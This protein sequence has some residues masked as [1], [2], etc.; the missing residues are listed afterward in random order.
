[1]PI[2]NHL[3]PN[4][5][6]SVL[7]DALAQK[8]GPDKAHDYW[9]AIRTEQFLSKPENDW[10]DNITD[11]LLQ[12]VDDNYE[13]SVAWVEEKLLGKVSYINHSGGAN[14]SD[15][16]WDTIGHEFGVTDHRHYWHGKQTPTGNVEITNEQ[17]EEGW[18][19]VKEANK[20]LHR[21]PDAYKSLL[22]RNWFQVKNAEAIF[23]IGKLAGPK[24]V[25]GGTGWAVQMAI[26]AR[27][28]V[29]MYDQE[30]AQWYKYDYSQNLF[31]P[32]STPVLTKN[33]A[34]IGTRE[35]NSLGREAIKDVYKKT[36]A[37]QKEVPEIKPIAQPTPTEIVKTNLEPNDNKIRGLNTRDSEEVM[38]D[39]VKFLYNEA[40]ANP[41][42]LYHIDYEYKGDKFRFPSGYTARELANIFDGSGTSTPSNVRFTEG[43][44]RL[45][46]NSSKRILESLPRLPSDII[47]RDEV[48]ITYLADRILLPKYDD[49]GKLQGYFKASEQQDIIDSALYLAHSF[50]LRDPNFGANAIVKTFKGFQ[51]YAA[52]D[53]KSDWA[54]VHDQ[55][56]R[57]AEEMLDQM[58]QLGYSVSPK[59]RFKILQAVERLEDLKGLDSKVFDET[60][61][62]YDEDL[63][64][65]DEENKQFIE[66]VGHGLKDWGEVS[67]EHDPKDTASARMKMFIATLPD[68]DR[69]KF[70]PDEKGLIMSRPASNLEKWADE[71]PREL[72]ALADQVNRKGFWMEDRTTTERMASILEQAHPILPRKTFLNTPKLID[73][74]S[75][76]QDILETLADSPVHDYNTYKGVLQATG[77]PNLIN[78]VSALDKAD[79]QVRN[80]FARLVSMQ[81]T[82]FSM[83]LFNKSEDA[84]GTHYTLRNIVSNRY[85]Q[86]NTIVKN[87]RENQKLSDIMKINEL[88]QR[89]IDV[90]R[91]RNKW[92]NAL[93]TLQKLDWKNSKD[94]TRGKKFIQDVLNIS[95]VHLTDDMMDYLFGQTK[96]K[97][98][99]QLDEN[100]WLLTKGTSLA[101]GIKK[102]FAVSEDGQPLG[103]FSAFIMKMAGIS[104]ANDISTTE[105][106][107]DIESRAEMNNPLYTENTTMQILSKVAAMFTPVL[108]SGTSKSSEGKTIWDYTMHTKLSHQ[109][110]DL[111]QNTEEFLQRYEGVDIAK[112]NFLLKTLKDVPYYKDR[113]RLMYMD[114]MK[115]QWGKRGTTRANMSDREQMLMSLSLFQNQGN[116]F[117]KVPS[118]HYMS[119]THSDKTTTPLLMNMPKID[120]GSHDKTPAWVV[121]KIDSAFY[122]IFKAE[123][124][125][126][127]NQSKIDFNDSRYD[128]GKSLFYF[129]P[130]FNK[131]AMSKMVETGFLSDREFKTIWSNGDALTK[132]I[133]EPELGVINKILNK[134]VEDRVNT[135]LEAW[136]KNGIVTEDSHLFDKKYTDKLLAKVGIKAERPETSDV[137]DVK[138][139]Y[140]KGGQHLEDAEIH[141]ITVRYAAKDYA[142]NHFIHNVGMS[143]LF[144]GD[145]A[146]TFKKG[147]SDMESVDLTLKEYGKRL[148]KDIAPGLDPYFRP[149]DKEFN[150]I[151]LADVNQKEAY[152]FNLDKIFPDYSKVNGTDAQEFTTVAEHLKVAYANGM[153]TTKTFDEMMQIVNNSNG[154]YYEFTNPEHLSV[155][156]QPVKPV[157]AGK[158]SAQD[159]AILE[160]YIKTSSIPLYPPATS[161]LELDGLRTYMEK[162]NLD[163][164]PFESGKKIGSP[165]NPVSF[166]SSDGKFKEPDITTVQRGTVRL[167]RSGFR[168]QQEVPYDETKEAIKTVSQMNKLI[169]EGID[170]ISNFKI[171]GKT[172]SGSELRQMKEDIRK[173]MIGK[174]Y[175]DFLQSW[176]IDKN[177]IQD[178]SIIYDKLLNG[179]GKDRLS[180]NERISLSARDADGNLFIPLQFNT[181]ADNLESLLMSMVKDIAQVKMPGKSFVQASSVGWKFKEGGV[182]N[183]KIVWAEDHHGGSLRTL[184]KDEITGEMKPAEVLIPFNFTDH[185]G[186]PMNV[187]DFMIEK[188]GK[189]ILD[190]SKVPK[191][192]T[193]LIGARI[194]NQGH[195]SMAAI[196]VVG[197]LPKNMG[198]TVVVPAGFT[199]QMGAD[200]DVDKLYTYRR[201]YKYDPETRTFSQDQEEMAGHQTDYFNVHWSVLTH[202]EMAERILKP[203]DK[204]DL[205]EENE[206]L[207]PVKQEGYNYF[208]H[209]SQLQDFQNGKDAK[210]L[211]GLTSLAVTFNAV[212]Q[213]K[214]LHFAQDVVHVSPEGK[215]YTTLERSHILIKDEH[216]GELRKLT[217]L[218]GNGKSHYTR[219]DG[220]AIPK[221]GSSI[222]TKS[223][224]HS[225]VQSAAVDN[226]KDRAL[227]NLNVTPDTYPAL[228]A[229]LQLETE[230]GWAA[231]LKYGT[232]LLTQPIIKEFATEMKKGNDSLSTAYDANLK[233]SVIN[234]LL[235]KYEGEHEITQEEL[236]AVQFDPQLLKK[237]QEMDPTSK[238]YAIHQVAALQLFEKLHDLGERKSQI[239][240]YFNQDTQGA[241]PN[242][243]TALDKSDKLTKLEQAPIAGAN[244]IFWN[245]K[246]GTTEQGYTASATTGVAANILTQLLPYDKYYPLFNRLTAISGRQSMSIDDQRSVLRATRS[247]LYNSGQHWW[248]DAHAER[249]RLF[250][251]QGESLSLARRLEQVKR[252]WGKDNYF[253]QRLDPVIG[254]TTSTPDFLEY[255][256]A[257]VGRIDEENNNRA[258]TELLMSPE[259]EKRKLGEDLLRYAFL[260]GGVQDQNSFVKFAPAAYIS[261]T[262]FGNMLKDKGERLLEPDMNAMQLMPGFEHQY[263]QHNPEKAFQITREVFGNIPAEL[264]YPETFFVP[265]EHR[266]KLL[267]DP[268]NY[269]YRD[270]VSYRSPSENKWVLY[271]NNPGDISGAYTRVDILGNTYTDEY[272]G[273]RSGIIR[274]IFTENRAMA[275][276]LPAMSM[277]GMAQQDINEDK[278]FHGTSHY[279]RLGIREGKGLDHMEK[280]L[281]NIRD[282]EEVPQ[283]LRAVADLFSKSGISKYETDAR[284]LMK[285]GF[286]P[287]IEFQSKAGVDGQATYD[288][289]IMLNPKTQSIERAA[290]TYLHEYT[291]QRLMHIIT[292]AGFDVSNRK[293]IESDSRLAKKYK[294]IQE[295]FEKH[296]PEAVEHL[297]QLDIMRYTVNQELRRRVGEQA[298]REME[299]KLADGKPLN[300]DEVLL[301]H[302]NNLQEFVTGIM[303]DRDTQELLNSFKSDN[304][305][306]SFLQKVWR[307]LTDLITSIFKGFKVDKESKL[308]EAMY[309]TI[310]LLQ[311]NSEYVG[312]ITDSLLSGK[313]IRVPTEKMSRGLRGA[314]EAYERDPDITKDDMGLTIHAKVQKVDI[315][316]PIGKITDRLKD[317]L[318]KAYRDISKGTKQERVAAR[319]RYNELRQDYNDLVRERNQAAIQKIAKKQLEWID[320]VLVSRTKNA[321]ITQAAIDAANIWGNMT[322]IMYGD[323]TGFATPDPTLASLEQEAQLNRI[324]LVNRNAAEVV[325]NSLQ[326]RVTIMPTDLKDNLKDVDTA[327]SLFLTLSRVK[328]KLISGIG[329]MTR[330]AANN[331]DE[332]L[333]RVHERLMGLEKQMKKLNIRS[334]D[335]LQEKSWGLLDRISNGW[336]EHMSKLNQ[337]R[338]QTLDGIAKTEGLTEQVKRERVNKTWEK[339]WQDVKKTNTFVDIRQLFNT[340]DGS[341]LDPAKIQEATD[342]LAQEV[343]SHEYAKEL[344]EK[345]RGKFKDY[346]EERNIQKEW[347]DSQIHLSDEEKKGKTPQEQEAIR[348]KRMEDEL[349]KWLQWNSPHEFLNKMSGKGGTKY[350]ND[351][352][353]WVVMAP[354]QDTGYYDGRWLALQQSPER[355]KIFDEYKS[356]IQEMT[357]Y[358]PPDH[359]EKLPDGFFPMVSNETVNEL[360][361]MIRKLKNFDSTLLNIFT[362][363]EAQEYARL[364]PDEIPIMYTRS[365]KYTED[366]ANRSKDLIKVAQAFA[367]MAVHYHHMS[368]ILDE[369]NLA[370][371]IVKEANAQRTAGN[372]EGPVLTN[373][374]K[375]I[376]FNK[377]RLIFN[378]PNQL[379]GKVDLAIHSM[380]P[381]KALRIQNEIKKLNQ[382]KVKIQQE[383]R[384]KQDNGEWDTEAEQK[385]INDIDKKLNE[386]DKNARYIYGSKVADHLISVNQIKALSYNPFSALGNFTFALISGRTYASGRTDYDPTHWR[387]AMGIMTHAMK[388]YY[389]FGAGMDS[390]AKKIRALMERSQVM[391]EIGIGELKNGHSPSHLKE[392]LSPFNWQKSGDYY[393][394]GS[395]MVAMMLKKEVEVID[396]ETGEK[397]KVRLWDA[398]NEEGKWD[399]ERY[400]DNPNWFHEDVSQQ[401]EWNKF[402]DK[403]RGAAT[404]VFGN[405]DKNSPLLAK[406][407]AIGRLV[408]Q[409]RMSWFPEGLNARFGGEHFDPVLGRDVKGRYRSFGTLGLM[410]SS[411]IMI[412]SLLDMLPGI[413]IDRFQGLTDKDGN[414]IKDVDRENMMR[415]FTGLA[416]TMGIAAS[417]IAMRALYDDKHKGKKKTSD[418]MTRQLVINMLIRNQQDLMMYASPSVWDTVTGNVIPATTVLTDSWRAIKATNHYLFGDTSKD[419]HAARTWLLKITKATPI[420]NNINKAQY[421]FNRD[422]DAIQR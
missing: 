309:H 267:A 225:T 343:G 154:K 399:T 283:H 294:D 266:E 188:D 192:L 197:F 125:R 82:N 304:Y 380:N 370:E 218:S 171:D 30:H 124:N 134:V 348:N 85:S 326:G 6:K 39:K 86:R 137:R 298:V 235:S 221:D 383:I 141:D 163:R 151:T 131:E 378:K 321:A 63:Q 13:P 361:G 275:E 201:P 377:D 354:K 91:A 291:H 143:Q 204:P 146:M 169:V 11:E 236:D 287:G 365:T 412:R 34:G 295:Q 317:Q 98:T 310:S 384:E 213:N 325:V 224:N 109:I 145:P 351:G 206:V 308:Y 284:T 297:R 391:S 341:E 57:V 411:V 189:R 253:L 379:E 402:R 276:V 396:K 77:R 302:T 107:A 97:T 72:K 18:Q 252:T 395:M 104:N 207:K 173:A 40:L 344:V 89:V 257:S 419:K 122:N 270:W 196:K 386:Y 132:Q 281:D 369:V 330:S 56:V 96:N 300:H 268:N 126:I 254:D 150:S 158:R 123:H 102:Q 172:V 403:M 389:T 269:T 248:R 10:M 65:S 329:L 14:G 350:I 155:I 367:F 231:N 108:H 336:H 194:P 414:A 185:E 405:Q 187:E 180:I 95:G 62:D 262:E 200:F 105:D 322:E 240:S 79:Q 323:T 2:C 273:E 327:S 68:M 239:Q 176:G 346:L 133:G 228:D 101:G 362:A 338:E 28:P 42:K 136:K 8:Y 408:G 41:D 195:S 129:L 215:T 37:E 186:R 303:T 121:G 46:N 181:A 117:N 347:L 328:P 366:E 66:A 280:V 230:N 363:T 216:T 371:S 388:N 164:A 149:E 167:D 373:A 319:L 76:F 410:T 233:N 364:K 415:N 1:M 208:D 307:K 407:Y 147:K 140:S 360:S 382:E 160:D 32:Q 69:G 381:A 183:S 138:T 278:Y 16:A 73:F 23:A 313:D 119:L 359:S 80:E 61:P 324:R 277:Q 249:A 184:S 4:G 305:P 272:N 148:A 349:G 243:L 337:E 118:V 237:A 142:L 418:E 246:G 100:M 387:Q 217:N 390:T 420:L 168:I 135:T 342:K 191:E 161:G 15:T 55:R 53:P 251:S 285:N 78:L 177:I 31:I 296:Y 409:F 17:L 292:A 178:K 226:A 255:Q 110:I 357:S 83:L 332:H 315:P 335:F 90:D 51:T 211:V 50:L 12:H 139:T 394:K 345:A 234:R 159:G 64:V 212:I 422:L 49:Q 45:I 22:S 93:G 421:M 26:D 355:K 413:H 174:Q 259:E 202:P 376:A 116:G 120:I 279:E 58:A 331:R 219:E 244:D 52:R 393:A 227:D 35:L 175:Q 210:T 265:D 368:P 320:K 144:Y 264:N 214:N 314:F 198:D 128:R 182:D 43:M 71:H 400:M 36:F 286:K 223:D 114:G 199:K 245:E 152:L 333:G 353:R 153:I 157:F 334:Q 162:N 47:N 29:N 75:T 293:I 306:E 392:A 70:T 103:M 339:Y 406:K 288:G 25:A 258:W 166:F 170:D 21:K 238:E 9:S 318:D 261:N 352:G 385:K 179:S 397:S 372:Q 38:I 203:L 209:I 220:G 260:T 416:W 130:E 374:L 113:I 111:K 232:R 5:Q 205:K 356:L 54:Y 67:F 271:R 127:I 193:E 417:I 289:R 3:A 27:K 106:K 74:E 24:T 115:P 165:T 33:F 99:G 87:W 19:H 358:L 88:G 229:L 290:E 84:D 247:F 59:N 311:P 398:L 250:Y 282:N 112:N 190:Y 156:M 340:V 316:G 7:Y 404:I 44:Q 92:F 222:R 94:F 274:S 301:Y 60:H 401:K 241:G 242:I 263:I 256:A 20:T 81:Y 375:Q 312:D 299:N 48:A